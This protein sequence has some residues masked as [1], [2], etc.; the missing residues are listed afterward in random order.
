MLYFFFFLFW[1]KTDLVSDEI[2]YVTGE[3]SKP[4]VE[5][6]PGSSRLLIL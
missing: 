1:W 3:I 6:W 2:G 5:V 4:S